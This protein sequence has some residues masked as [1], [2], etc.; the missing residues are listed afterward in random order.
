MTSRPLSPIFSSPLKKLTQG[1]SLSMIDATSPF[2]EWTQNHVSSFCILILFATNQG[3]DLFNIYGSPFFTKIIAFLVPTIISVF[4]PVWLGL[5]WSW[6]DTSLT[7]SSHTTCPQV[8]LSSFDL[9]GDKDDDAED[10]YSDH[11]LAGTWPITWSNVCQADIR[12]VPCIIFPYCWSL[13]C[14]EQSNGFIQ[15]FMLYMCWKRKLAKVEYSGT[16]VPEK[17]STKD[18]KMRCSVSNSFH[19]FFRFICGC[20]LDQFCCTSGGHSW[21]NGRLKSNPM[22]NIIVFGK[23]SNTT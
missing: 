2:V 21:P 17:Y 3:R 16:P 11:N 8:T 6:V 19:H 14:I 5:R 13:S 4:C 9:A 12:E 22:F 15:I 10:I 1:Q 7:T 18:Y 23:L 20:V